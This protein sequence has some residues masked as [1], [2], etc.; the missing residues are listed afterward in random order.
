MYDYTA[1]HPTFLQTDRWTRTD[2]HL[3]GLAR[4]PQGPSS[5][6]SRSRNKKRL[7]PAS[8]ALTH[9][10]SAPAAWSRLDEAD[11]H[12]AARRQ[13]AS[14]R[15]LAAHTCVDADVT[16]KRHRPRSC[17]SV[18]SSCEGADG[19]SPRVF[20]RNSHVDGLQSCSP[21]RQRG[22]SPLLDTFALARTLWI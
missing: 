16:P 4:H 9:I 5:S 1:F 12:R 2:L 15:A 13:A 10:A 22:F 3:H 20:W 11:A 17:L 6:S 7:P 19:S 21:R 14:P 8:L 18:T